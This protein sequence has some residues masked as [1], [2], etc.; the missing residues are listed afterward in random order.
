MRQL[1][2]PRMCLAIAIVL[3]ICCQV[4]YGQRRSPQRHF[5]ELERASLAEPF[6]GLTTDGK[7]VGGLYP[8]QTT[9]VSTE[10][11]QEA[12]KAFLAGL[13]KEQRKKTLFP[14]DDSEWRKWGNVHFYV[15]QGV[16]FKEMNKKQRELG[17]ELLKAGLSAK[18]LK[19]T[20]DV[21]RLNETLA[22][23]KNN[24]DEWG[25]SL[26]WI[27]I[28]GEPSATK[29]WG[30]QLDGH[31][32][33]I[34]YFVLGDQVVMTPV[35]MGS[36]PTE[37]KSGKYK[38]TIVL[39]D[40]QNKGLALM[41]S[42]TPSQRTKA[43]IQGKKGP[44]NNVAEAFRDNL[45]LDY[46]GIPASGFNDKQKKLL[47]E[48]VSEY[49]GNIDDGHARVKMSEVRKHLDKTHFAWIGTVGPDAVFYYRIQSPVVLIEFDHQRPIG[50]RRTGIPSREHTHTVIRTPNGNDYGKDLLR[51]HHADHD[52]DHDHQ[53]E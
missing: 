43:T 6:K 33:N 19:K 16:S 41:T 53:H 18:G 35:F 9:G 13:N 21:M 24:F 4:S 15:R 5:A 3:F 49:V 52:H 30:W 42:L 47:L 39:Q 31:H 48:V 8:V 34:N 36:E 44:T 45:V 25:E 1:L 23:I 22:E 28:M 32:V 27:T 20:R 7:V 11:V 37:A 46:A 29:P 51:Q 50:L 2:P 12:A 40:E 10:P 26:Y 14:V 38:G 17:F